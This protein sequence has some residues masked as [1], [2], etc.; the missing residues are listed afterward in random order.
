MVRGF[1]RATANVP[2][3]TRV[4][5]SPRF[6][7]PRMLAII[8][9]SARSAA[10]LDNP[11]A[12]AMRFTRSTRVKSHSERAARV[13]HHRLR[14]GGMTLCLRQ[15]LEGLAGHWPNERGN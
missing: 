14:D 1:R 5:A 8:A 10:A 12:G 11:A 9:R 7:E 15:P 13:V 4:T 2:K 6:S 3:P